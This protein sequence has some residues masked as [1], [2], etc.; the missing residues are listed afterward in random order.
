MLQIRS[1]SFPAATLADEAA[2][3]RWLGVAFS[4]VIRTKFLDDLLD[5]AVASGVRG[6]C[7]PLPDHSGIRSCVPRL[8]S[9]QRHPAPDEV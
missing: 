1:R 2:R 7:R 4:I 6:F 3:R 8:D 9:H 5:W